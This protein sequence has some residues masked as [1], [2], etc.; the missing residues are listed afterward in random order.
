[1]TEPDA[2][3]QMAT[4]RRPSIGRWVV[5]GLASLTALV[6]FLALVIVSQ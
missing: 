3:G 4:P 6:L 2:C 1:M 5:D